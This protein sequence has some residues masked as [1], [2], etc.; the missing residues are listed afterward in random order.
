MSKWIVLVLGLA[1]AACGDDDGERV[2]D[3]RDAGS[4]EEGTLLAIEL[5]W[6]EQPEADNYVPGTCASA[7]AR[8]ME[9]TLTNED[10]TE[11]ASRSEPCAD[12]IDVYDPAPDTYTL[13]LT[14]F[15]E[16]DDPRWS[17]ACTGLTIA[18][19]DVFHDCEVEES[20]R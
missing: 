13:E 18:R 1:L 3:A 16:N 8:W 9:W 11:L 20:A 5:F 7:G 17:A 2:P 4:G 12:G 10:G 14:G 19:S 6:D 15:D